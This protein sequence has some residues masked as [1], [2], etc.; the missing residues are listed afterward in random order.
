MM[1]LQSIR[2]WHKD[3]L[4]YYKR[5]KYIIGCNWKLKSRLFFTNSIENLSYK[6]LKIV[7]Y[8]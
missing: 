4:F 5:K 1:I 3:I 6:G 7:P 2:N 8:L